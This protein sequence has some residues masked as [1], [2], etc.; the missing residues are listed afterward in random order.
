MN[1]FP[2]MPRWTS[3]TPVGVATDALVSAVPSLG[4]RH[5]AARSADTAVMASEMRCERF[6]TFVQKCATIAPYRAVR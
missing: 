5:E 1:S 3:A 6:I 4:A 2:E